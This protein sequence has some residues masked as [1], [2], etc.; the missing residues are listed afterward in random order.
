MRQS[1][2][3]AVLAIAGAAAAGGTVASDVSLAGLLDEL[4]VLDTLAEWP[5]P[6]FRIGM[7][8][9]RDP[10]STAPDAPGWFDNVDYG[11]FLGIEDHDGRTE[12]V[13]LDLTGSGVITR[14][15]S[16][17]PVGVIRIY[18]DG[19]GLPAIEAPMSAWL[20]GEID[21]FVAP[22]NHRA[23]FGFTSYFPI[24]FASAVRVTADS[25]QPS[26]GAGLFYEIE[27]RTYG[28]EVVVESFDSGRLAELL[29]KIQTVAATWQNPAMIQGGG[30]GAQTVSAIVAVGAPP[31][32]V[33][34]A[35]AGGPGAIVRELRVRPGFS[36]ESSLRAV[37]LSIAFD[38]EIAVAVPLGDFFGSGPGSY[39]H[40][41]MPLAM[42]WD[43]TRVSRWPMPF[44]DSMSLQFIG[45]AGLTGVID[46][47]IVIESHTP[48]PRSLRFHAGWRTDHG[49]GPRPPRDW[50]LVTLQGRGQ[51]VGTTLNV[52]HPFISPLDWWGEGDAKV[53]VDDGASPAIFGTGTEDH[54]G[55][56]WA[57]RSMFQHAL[58]AQTRCDCW[59]AFRGYSSV[60]RFRALDRIPFENSL[61]FDLEQIQVAGNP[62]QSVVFDAV[63]YWYATPN[64]T[65]DLGSTAASSRTVP[66]LPQRTDRVLPGTV[67]EGESMTTIAAPGLGSAPRST[68]NHEFS[69]RIWRGQMQ[70]VNH[71]TATGQVFDLGFNL[72]SSGEQCIL[73][74]FTRSPF[75]GLHAFEID[76]HTAGALDLWDPLTLPAPGVSLGVHTLAAG[77]HTLRTQVT[78][79]N[80]SS[81]CASCR[82]LGVDALALV[83]RAVAAAGPV[84][85]VARERLSWTLSAANYDIVA[86]DL[87]LLRSSGGDFTAATQDCVASMVEAS[88]WPLT[89]TPPP[90]SGFWFLVRGTGCFPA[91]F[92]SGGAQQIGTRDDE[93]LAAVSCP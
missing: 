52:A 93:I 50:N 34:A 54:F 1:R 8:S 36:D 12:Y 70:R 51:Y 43:G 71:G 59:P 81:T 37:E 91:T 25:N 68:A 10:S 14:I 39:L 18:I 92:D 77:T 33:S 90:G 88:A 79:S 4:I 35:I 78:G 67:I 72:S 80:P 22:I 15:W 40:E 44:S 38:G 5:F 56:G 46:V 6:E 24:P 41:S 73:G 21:P 28:P 42:R 83:P 30:A 7:A 60:N 16:A 32:V 61:R 75:A 11:H 64:T 27:Y 19:A 23:N 17:N 48:S 86:G 9:S 45:T 49:P 53:W 69:G 62:E 76:G 63:S 26:L 85:S 87:G 13:M 65:D 47:E 89:S 74:F 31:I 57:A 2:M 3:G 84:L 20:A 29:P 55:Y 58:H 66:P 82:Y